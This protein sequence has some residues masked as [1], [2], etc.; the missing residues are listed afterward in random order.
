MIRVTFFVEKLLDRQEYSCQEYR[1]IRWIHTY[2]WYAS[3][4]N[5]LSI[6]SQIQYVH[7]MDSRSTRNDR[8]RGSETNRAPCADR[9]IIRFIVYR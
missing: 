9:A 4:E 7:V 8:V 2:G 3:A 5:E 1:G 6:F